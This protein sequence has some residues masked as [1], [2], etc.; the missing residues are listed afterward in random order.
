MLD[1][2]YTLNGFTD[3]VHWLREMSYK[4]ENFQPLADAH[5]IYKAICP[6]LGNATIDNKRL[7]MLNVISMVNKARKDYLKNHVVA[8]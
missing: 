5:S 8:S 6:D 1:F 2:P 7:A 3:A 4:H